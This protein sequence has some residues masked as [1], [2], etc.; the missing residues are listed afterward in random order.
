MHANP[1][2][3]ALPSRRMD[4]RLRSL[5]SGRTAERRRRRSTDPLE[6]LTLMLDAVRR[7]PGVSAIAVADAS[8]LLIA[9]AGLAR[10]C[11]ELAALGAAQ[12]PESPRELPFPL[13]ENAEASTVPL[14]RS[15][16]VVCLEGDPNVRERSRTRVA[17][18]CRRILGRA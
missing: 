4:S 7:E 9:G 11:E 17:Q 16:I 8:G 13:Y 15:S 12:A 6:A 14:G 1:T 3:D 18:G 2:D 5:P 10:A